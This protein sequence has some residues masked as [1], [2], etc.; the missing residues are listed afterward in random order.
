MTVRQP[1]PISEN[2][3]VC[4]QLLDMQ[5]V[6]D[7]RTFLLVEQGLFFTSQDL[8]HP[9]T[10]AIGVGIQEQMP[11]VLAEDFLFLA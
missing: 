2:I 7:A 8:S 9:D 3:E 6:S 1:Y 4:R 10:V 11:E 5:A